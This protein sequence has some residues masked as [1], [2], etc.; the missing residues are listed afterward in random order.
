LLFK[1]GLHMIFRPA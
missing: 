1:L